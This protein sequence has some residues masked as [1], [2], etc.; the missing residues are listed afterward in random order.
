MDEPRK[1]MALLTLEK[2][3]QTVGDGWR[4][5]LQG[6]ID[7][8]SAALRETP[9]TGEIPEPLFQAASDLLVYAARIM[10]GSLDFEALKSPGIVV[11]VGLNDR[12]IC[13]CALS[14]P[15]TAAL[16]AERRNAMN[17]QKH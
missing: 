6:A 12:N 8:A 2:L 9:E 1:N 13:M 10:H 14:S 11:D 3:A 5:E 17:A 15:A 7:A 16:D 4:G